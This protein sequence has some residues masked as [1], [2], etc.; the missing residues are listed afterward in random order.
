MDRPLATV[1]TETLQA[2]ET[3]LSAARRLD[4]EVLADATASR[5]DLHFELELLAGHDPPALDDEIMDL[6]HQLKE[7]DVR[8]SRVLGAAQGVFRDIL[9]GDEPQTYGASGRLRGY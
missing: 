2:A 1:L 9:Q 4:A 7:T 5:Q 8:L 6:V 3:Q